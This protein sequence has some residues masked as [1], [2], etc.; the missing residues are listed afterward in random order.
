MTLSSL[1]RVLYSYSNDIQYIQYTTNTKTASKVLFGFFFSLGVLDRVIAACGCSSTLELLIG[2][3]ES[4][5]TPHDSHMTSP[6]VSM[7]TKAEETAESR[8]PNSI[9]SIANEAV[10]REREK[11]GGG[12]DNMV[13]RGGV[14]K[15]LLLLLRSKLTAESWKKQPTAKHALIWTLRQLKARE[16]YILYCIYE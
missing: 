12:R 8:G 2:R 15:S 1:G 16:L 11:D 4:H 10:G 13:F 5:D 3:P 9:A 7:A 14:I 6:Y